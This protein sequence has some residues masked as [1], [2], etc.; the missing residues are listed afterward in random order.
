MHVFLRLLAFLALMAPA[1]RA[2]DLGFKDVTLGTSLAHFVKT[3]EH[4]CEGDPRRAPALSCGP[5]T[6]PG[7]KSDPTGYRK[8]GMVAATK[9]FEFENHDRPTGTNDTIAGVPANVTYWFFAAEAADWDDVA[10]PYAASVSPAIKTWND[11]NESQW[12]SASKIHLGIIR[13]RFSP[14]DFSTVSSA[15]E[16]KYGTPSSSTR[17]ID[18]RVLSWDISPDDHVTAAEH[19]CQLST[20]EIT[21]DSIKRRAKAFFEAASKANAADL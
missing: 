1:V 18:G 7:A 15:L 19:T 4:P 13:V 9:T 21:R 3:F 12:T 2:D 6:A 8:M 11:W 5:L 17:T 14:A 16:A 10:Q 20:V